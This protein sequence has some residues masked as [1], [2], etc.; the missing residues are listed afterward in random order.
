MIGAPPRPSGGVAEPVGKLPRPFW[1]IWAGTLVNRCGSFVMPFLTLYLTQERQLSIAQA[2]GVVALWGAGGSVAAPL[3]GYLADHIGRR[4]T[5]LTALGL[6]GVGM[7][8]LGFVD[9]IAVLAALIFVV[10]ILTEM[11]RPAMSAAIADLVPPAD[12]L[13]AYGLV[14]WVINLGFAIGLAVGGVLAGFSFR[15]LFVGDGLTTLLFAA[16][17]WLGVPETLPA[18]AP[19]PHGAAAESTWSRLVVPFRDRTFVALIGLHFALWVVFMQNSTTFPLDMTAHGVPKSTFGLILGLNGVLIVLIQPVLG[20]FLTRRDRSR[21]LA[22]GALL[23]G[24]GFGLNALVRIAPLY[25]LGVVIWT[26]GEIAVLP[27]SSSVVADL[28][29]RDIRGRYQGAWGLASGLAA[30]AAAPLG[31]LLLQSFGSV[32]LWSSCLAVGAVI[33]VGHLVLGPSLRRARAERAAAH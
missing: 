30:S 23:V 11:Y 15:W 24:M 21:T 29:P 7:I 20:P 6:G 26:V 17:I 5:M 22:V 4:T 19:A 13:R 16:V 8:A 3:G 10:T 9:R 14:Y 12:R 31:A 1:F 2:G 25:A 32:A 28:A 33:A 18:R 27:V